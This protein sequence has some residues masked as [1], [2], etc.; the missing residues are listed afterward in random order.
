MPGSTSTA[1]VPRADPAWAVSVALPG[2]TAVRMPSA[3]TRATLG[4]LLDH[5]MASRDRSL[6]FVNARADIRSCWPTTIFPTGVRTSTRLAGPGTMRMSSGST[7]G[8]VPGTSA[9]TLIGILPTELAISVPAES[10]SPF[11]LP[12]ARNEADD[13]VVDLPTAGVARLGAEPHGVAGR[14][15]AC[16]GRDDDSRDG[17][18]GD[19]S[20]R[21]AAPAGPPAARIERK[22]VDGMGVSS[23]GGE[24]RE[25]RTGTP[26]RP[27]SGGRR[28]MSMR[29]EPIDEALTRA[30]ARG[31]DVD[32]SP[33]RR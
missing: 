4:A 6:T 7:F 3:S 2:E 15:L 22:E 8:R 32:E 13:G 17:R 9:T 12:A 27:T 1:L 20:A 5:R 25:Q 11:T 10:T 29:L 16:R 19:G 33:A 14:H 18:L 24:Q 23:G 31:P 28:V 21:A 30:A 26:A